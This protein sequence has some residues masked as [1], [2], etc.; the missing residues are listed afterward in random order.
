MSDIP[1][2]RI[3]SSLNDLD[4]LMS[5]K[6]LLNLMF[7]STVAPKMTLLGLSMWNGSPKILY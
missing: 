6:T 7:P 4:S 5:S 2:I 3:L 1:G